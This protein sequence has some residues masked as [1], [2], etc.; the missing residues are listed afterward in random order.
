MTTR[1]VCGLLRGALYHIY[2][3]LVMFE[4]LQMP[5]DTLRDLVASALAALVDPDPED[6]AGARSVLEEARDLLE[7][8]ASPPDRL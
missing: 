4:W 6:I 8:G 2:N 3:A 1:S 7:G 5:A